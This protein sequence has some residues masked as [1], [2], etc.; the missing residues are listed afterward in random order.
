MELQKIY[1]YASSFSF[2]SKIDQTYLFAEYAQGIK[3]H[4]PIFE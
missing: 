3:W 4:S 1:L 2:I